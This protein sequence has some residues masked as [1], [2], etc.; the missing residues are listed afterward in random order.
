MSRIASRVCAGVLG[1]LLVPGLLFSA[2]NNSANN[3]SAANGATNAAPGA[4]AAPAAV[5]LDPLLRLMLAQGLVS[6]EE[7]AKLAGVPSSE[8]RDRLLLLLLAKNKSALSAADLNALNAPANSAVAATDPA[9][10]AD[11]VIDFGQ[12]SGPP[13]PP[14]TLPPSGPIP[15]V[16]PIRVMQVTPAKREGVIP[17]LAIGKNVHIQPYGFIKASAV[18]D[19]SS[20]YGNDFPLPGFIG[21]INGPDAF[22]EFHIKARFIRIGSNFE[23]M[24]T[25]KVVVTGKIEGDF[26]G[27]F[28]RANNRNISSVRS[29]MFSFRVG[30]GRIDWHTTD[31]TSLFFL[32]GQDWT[33][34]ASSTLPNLF[35]TTGLGVGF[36]TT[37][38]RDPQFRVGLNH[39]FSSSVSL[40]PEFAI[41]LPAFGNLPSNVAD[42]LG[43]GERQGADSGKPEIQAR[44][45]T[46]F[47]LDHAAGVA[48]AQ[49]IVSGV[50]GQRTV[51]VLASAVPAAFKAAFPSGAQ[52]S[53][54]RNAWTGEIQ[55][56]T[57]FATII[58]KY[59]NGSDLRYYF[60]NQLLS[61][62]PNTTGLTGTATAP[63][64]DGSSTVVFGNLAGVP[65]IAPQI[66][67][68]GQGGFVN[69]GLPFSRWANA[70][71]TGRNAGWVGYLHYGFDE[72]LARDA[73]RAGGGRQKSD[74][75]AGTL[76]YKMNSFVTFVLE[77]SYYRTRAIPLTSTGLFPLFQ[78][79]P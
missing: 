77:E 35:E 12:A 62:F 55:L 29:N 64:V 31:T 18:Y 1:L 70:D 30:Y 9:A 26:E 72:A 61:N 73:R 19:T 44:L 32:A 5:P 39:K 8:L 36:G 6:Q 22:P 48:P 60:A 53:S 69:I 33:P 63:S 3:N 52:V 15:A 57:R 23:W 14:K 58:A 43:F 16:A 21:D 79:R 54:D 25:P 41:V 50:H 67:I 45:V 65:T 78:G 49:I 10:S 17:V 42:Q 68:R 7:V 24:D 4:P 40:S 75:A 38:E 20:P 74:V 27:N 66:P 51:T 2:D 13:Q 46:Q 56:P 34:F 71:P 37:Y 47:Q 76:Q 59:Y 11:A 28:S